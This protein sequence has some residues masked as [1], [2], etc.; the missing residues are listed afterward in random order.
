MLGR[1][2]AEPDPRGLQ[3]RGARIAGRIDLENIT[4]DLNVQLVACHLPDGLLLRDTSLLALILNGSRIG[5]SP[6]SNDPAID[7]DRLTARLM[8]LAG[9]T[10]TSTAG[11]GAI[12]LRDAHLGQLHCSWASSNW[13]VP[14]SA[15]DCGSTPPT[16]ARPTPGIRRWP[17][18]TAPPTPDSP[19]QDH[20]SGGC[21]CCA[22]T[23]PPT[24][25]SPTSN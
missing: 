23:P 14:A 19:N 21:G 13:P 16:P 12:R 6:A 15:A 22:S 18:S 25:P 1:L 8:G 2:A 17:T 3:L 10:V 24:P 20:S 4:R 11:G 7:A 9:T 5:P